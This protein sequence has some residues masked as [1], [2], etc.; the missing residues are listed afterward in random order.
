MPGA[1]LHRGQYWIVVLDHGRENGRR[2]RKWHYFTTKREA[3]AFQAQAAYHPAFGAGVGAFGSPKLRF[4]AYLEAWLRDYAEI[5]VRPSTL[6]RYKQLIRVHLIPGLGHVQISRLSPQSIETF[7]RGLHGKVSATTVHHIASILRQSLKQAIRWGLITQNPADLVEKPKRQ[8]ST[9]TLWTLDQAVHFLDAAR[10]TRHYLL[11]AT[12]LGTGLRLGEALS[13]Q[14]SD[15]DLARGVV[16]VRGGKTANARRAVLLPAELVRDLKAARGLGL[17]FPG[18]NPWTIRKCHFYP[19]VKRLGLPRIRLHDLRHLHGTFLLEAGADLASVSARLGHSSKAFTLQT[20]V[21][22]LTS[23]QE[24]AAAI[25]N[26]LFMQPEYNPLNK[27]E[28]RNPASIKG[29]VVPPAGFE[30]ALPA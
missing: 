11:Y 23:G 6:L 21:H 22:T 19:L 20:Y 10:D 12:L 13:L 1:L 2:I 8:R 18:A 17:V 4:R 3:L 15:V 14:W 26:V 29:N 9:P 25:S 30:P 24:K 28:L 16:L 7:Y 27:T 5:R